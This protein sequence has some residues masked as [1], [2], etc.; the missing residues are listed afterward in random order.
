[1][2]EKDWQ[3]ALQRR[4]VEALGD[5]LEG[6]APPDL[7]V[8]IARI[9]KG[10]AQMLE[11]MEVLQKLQYHPVL[12]MTPSEHSQAIINAGA[13]AVH[14]TAQQLRQAPPGPEN[15]RQQFAS[16]VGVGV[17]KGRQL[18]MLLWTAGA[19]LAVGLLLSHLRPFMPGVVIRS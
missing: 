2:R 7:S 4:A 15:E 3:V 5:T 6:Y 17:S 16:L 1:M 9:L 14:E 18:Q 10:Q 13:S 19:A 11:S 12:R 8:D